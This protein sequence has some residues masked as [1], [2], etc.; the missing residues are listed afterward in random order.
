MK[1]TIYYGAFCIVPGIIAQVD[2]S[3]T[4]LIEPLTNL[5]VKNFL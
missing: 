3:S 2:G 5:P 4:P 1:N